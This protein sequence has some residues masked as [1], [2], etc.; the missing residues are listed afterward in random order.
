[1]PPSM[2]DWLPAGHLV[3]FVLEVVAEVDTSAFHVR[4]RTG[5]AG[6]AGFDPDMLLALL[7][8]A[9]CHGQLSSRRIEELCRV[10]VAFRVICGNDAPDHVT[11]ARF[12]KANEQAVTGLFTQ[13]LSLCARAGLGRVGIVAIDGTKIAASAAM[14]ANR[15][16]DWLRAAAAGLVRQAGEVDAAE[17]ALFGDARGDELPAELADPR[18]RAARIREC[19]GQ[20]DEENAAA[21]AA[22]QAK[23]VEAARY[24]EQVRSGKPP[25]GPVPAAVDP[26]ELAQARLD[27]ERSAAATR[28][29]GWE[30]KAAAAA[31]AGRKMTGFPPAPV[32]EQGRV[33]RAAQALAAARDTAGKAAAREATQSPGGGSARQASTGKPAAAG[34][35]PQRNLTDPDSRILKTGNG[36]V[37]GYNAQIAATDDQLI[38]A[39]DAVQDANDSAQLE[40]MM[41]AAAAAAAH[42]AAHRD[43]A[44]RPRDGQGR[45]LPGTIGTVAADAGY[46]T[47]HNLTAPGP[48]RLIADTT[49]G[50]LAR[51]TQDQ[52]A[53]GEPP[54]G[55]TPRQA[56]NH[57]LRTEEGQAI[58]RR[59]SVTV[60]PV[61]GHLKD[62]IGLRRFS[63]RGLSAAKAEL[64][65]AAA[66]ANL[67]K[68]HRTG[69][70]PA[71]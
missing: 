69:W 3:W 6:R 68:I 10:D 25:L 55:A 12:R 8:Y 45:P 37:Q 13:V 40:P 19:L 65:F 57:R 14:A 64:K 66:C 54:P 61:N 32:G 20:I 7:I 24:T 27:A 44:T 47:E 17:D 39:T 53:T 46:D 60:E 41:H 56:M 62:R 29:A 1:M 16:G 59:R 67:L 34:K 28:I 23:R 36:W 33:V 42:L 58:Y 2:R 5:G 63:R 52:P 51:D 15:G 22:E 50:Q 21:V 49:R 30:V 31:A 71:T 26:V 18:S 4:A 11:V 9:Y 70:S 38:L 48:D 35:Q 43:E